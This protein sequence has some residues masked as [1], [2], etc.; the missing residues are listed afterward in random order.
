MV[1]ASM[2]P[3]MYQVSRTTFSPFTVNKCVFS[4]QISYVVIVFVAAFL[5]LSFALH[6][7][8]PRAG[9]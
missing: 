6:Y 8:L 2:A 3:G 5:P 4:T 7:R 9:I 1:R